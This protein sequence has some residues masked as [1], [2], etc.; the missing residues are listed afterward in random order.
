VVA[1]VLSVELPGLVVVL[2]EEMGQHLAQDR[3][4]LQP[5]EVAEGE[6]LAVLEQVLAALVA[7]AL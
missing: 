3:L 2:L 5:I 4:H 7:E 1:V 6:V